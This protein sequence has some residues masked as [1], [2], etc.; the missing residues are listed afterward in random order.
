MDRGAWQATVHGVSK[1]SDSIECLTLSLFTFHF[2]QDDLPSQDPL[3]DPICLI[4]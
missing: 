2:H 4:R 1:E 3:L